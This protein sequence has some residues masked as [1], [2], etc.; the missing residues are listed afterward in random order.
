[1]PPVGPERGAAREAALKPD[2]A[3]VVIRYF[4]LAAPIVDALNTP[5]AAAMPPKRKV[6][7]GLQLRLSA[8]VVS[9]EIPQFYGLQRP[10]N[11]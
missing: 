8:G 3:A 11:P 1:M 6:L 2:I 7:F 10:K 9:A 4:K 5:I